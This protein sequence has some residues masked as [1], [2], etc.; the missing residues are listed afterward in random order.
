MPELQQLIDEY[1]IASTQLANV[2]DKL[3]DT[4]TQVA[5]RYAKIWT[6]YYKGYGYPQDM[7]SLNWTISDDGKWVS[8]EW[9]DWWSYGGHDSGSFEFSVDFLFD[10]S[11]FDAFEERLIAEEEREKV[12]RE[13]ER[14]EKERQL[15]TT[16]KAK[17]DVVDDTVIAEN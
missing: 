3:R 12:K 6:M 13:K 14:E 16:L 1:I 7:Q 2:E 5:R 9:E 15:F 4:V 11:Q 8:I 17:Y 10:E